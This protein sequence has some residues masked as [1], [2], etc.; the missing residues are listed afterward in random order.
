MIGE[1]NFSDHGANRLGAS[2]LMQGLADGYFVLPYTIGNYLARTGP[3]D[4]GSDHAASKSVCHEVT[5]RTNQ[6]LNIGGSRSA[7]SFHREIG[8]LV[9]E[10]CG[11]ARNKAGLEKG[12]GLIADLKEQFWRDLR[13]PGSG[14]DINQQLE[15]AGR[16]ADFFELAEVMWLDASQREESCGAHFREE[17]QTEEGEAKRDD[18]A[19]SH[20]AVWEF[21]GDAPRRHVEPLVFENVTLSQRSYK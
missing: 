12:L 4:V 13:V 16:V 21:T 9:W 1:A 2:A 11:M 10:Y 6:L 15:L 3:S 20:A 14:A 8:G 18:D 19:F 17:H 5:N 7:D